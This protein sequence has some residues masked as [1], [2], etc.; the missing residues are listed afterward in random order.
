MNRAAYDTIQ[1]AWQSTIKVRA[2]CPTADKS[3]IGFTEYASPTWYQ[4]HGAVYFVKPAHSLTEEDIAELSEM[5]SFVNR[6]FIIAMSAILESYKVVP[7]RSNPD[8]S[9]EGG[10]HVQLVKW[11]RN[12]FA[13]GE[14]EYDNNKPE[15]VR[16]RKLLEKLLPIGAAKGQG[17]VTSIDTVLELLKDGVLKYISN[18]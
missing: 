2:L 10:E 5:A 17:F 11:L 6:S 8:L 3:A 16:T 18:I 4:I 7:Y 15:H 14:Y 12:H 9:V 13:H 1:K